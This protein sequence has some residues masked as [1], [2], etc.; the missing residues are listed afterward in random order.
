MMRGISMGEIDRMDTAQYLRVLACEI[1][2]SKEDRERAD[3]EKDAAS[4]NSIELRRG[5]IDMVL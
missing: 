2:M 5:K 1:K 3:A 4:G